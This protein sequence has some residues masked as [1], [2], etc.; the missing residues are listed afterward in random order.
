MPVSD[1]IHDSHRPANDSILLTLDV[2]LVCELSI[3]KSFANFVRQI[4]SGC[5]V[6]MNK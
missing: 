5:S 6:R 3:P 2:E 1:L 4:I